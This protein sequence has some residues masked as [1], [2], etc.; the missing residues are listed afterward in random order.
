MIYVGENTA[1]G[2]M[3]QILSEFDATVVGTAVR[4]QQYILENLIA[5]M[6]C[7]ALAM[8]TLISPFKTHGPSP[9]QRFSVLSSCVAAGKICATTRY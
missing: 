8:K 6:I 9:F 5:V 2:K 1:V 4:W 7:W 3:S